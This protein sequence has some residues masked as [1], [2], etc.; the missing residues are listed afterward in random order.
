MLL[1]EIQPCPALREFVRMYRIIDFKFPDGIII[2]KKSYPPRPEHCLQFVIRSITKI[3]YPGSKDDITMYPASL[4]GQHNI[5]NVREITSRELL[6]LQVVFQ[7]SALHRWFGLPTQ[8]L[9]NAMIDGNIFFGK[10]MD[11]ISERLCYAKNY[12]EMISIVEEFLRAQTRRM[13][14]QFHPVDQVFNMLLS[15]N[16]SFLLEKYAQL[17][18]LSYRQFDRKFMERAGIS[19]KEFLQVTRFDKVFRM[20]NRYPDRDWLTIALQCGYYDYQHL[21]KDYKYFTGKTPADFFSMDN[22]PERILG[23]S[24]T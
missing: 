4:L 19:P 11:F 7:P 10:E 17:A 15:G 21:T 6:S 1:N 24:E 14:K 2:P 22:A 12:D 18:C 20:K 13:K 8:E 16:D 23:D 9:T 3:T 5:V